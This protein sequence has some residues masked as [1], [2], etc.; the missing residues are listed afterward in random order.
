MGYDNTEI[1]CCV[2]GNKILENIKASMFC[3][4]LPI[5]KTFITKTIKI[6]YIMNYHTS[7]KI[8][9]DKTL[10]MIDFFL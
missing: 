4:N 8:G 5:N 9:Q 2:S 1:Y 10:R 3:K 7:K 6:W